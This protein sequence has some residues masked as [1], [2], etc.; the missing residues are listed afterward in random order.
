MGLTM[1]FLKFTAGCLTTSCTGL[2]GRFL[3]SRHSGK[4]E[5][6]KGRTTHDALECQL[7]QFDQEI[8][9]LNKRLAAERETR[10][11]NHL[12]ELN[13]IKL[14][15][16]MRQKCD[17]ETILRRSWPEG[18]LPH[19]WE[20]LLGRFN[21]D[22]TTIY[23][24]NRIGQGHALGDK[25]TLNPM[26]AIAGKLTDG[27]CRYGYQQL[28]NVRTVSVSFESDM[29][30]ES[31]F[32]AIRRDRS[33]MLVF[34][35]CDGTHVRIKTIYDGLI[36]GQLDFQ[37]DGRVNHRRGQH[38]LEPLVS[39]PLSLHDDIRE[40][41]SNQDPKLVGPHLE[42]KV[43]EYEQSVY[44][45]IGTTMIHPLI[46]EHAIFFP[47]LGLEPIARILST[48]QATSLEAANLWNDE[49]CQVLLKHTTRIKDELNRRRQL[50]EQR[51]QPQIAEQ[52]FA[53]IPCPQGET[54]NKREQTAIEQVQ[55]S[56][57]HNTL[58][59]QRMPFRSVYRIGGD[60]KE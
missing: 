1:S 11:D 35:T 5:F 53:E 6:G 16:L 23:V 29:M 27:F 51:H 58:Q 12:A 50:I 37:P 38:A 60:P 46:D 43:R 55:A 14:Q 8:A 48:E 59:Q 47:E 49:L 33:A 20:S 21:D 22:K 57:I 40:F 3:D 36:D 25:A 34:P 52:T 45:F 30:A 7:K 39:I 32:H 15:D 17:L 42:R 9:V 10:R 18:L 41:A 26:E 24:A 31:W 2:S 28:V 4:K 44:S 19:E 56:G 13:R 54:Q